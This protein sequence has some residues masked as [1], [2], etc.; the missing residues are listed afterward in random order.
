MGEKKNLGQLKN[1]KIYIQHQRDYKH[2]TK[3]VARY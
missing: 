2:T 3:N 1:K